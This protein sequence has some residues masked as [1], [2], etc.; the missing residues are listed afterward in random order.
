MKL[1]HNK[2]IFLCKQ[3]EKHVINKYYVKSLLCSDKIA[4]KK[5]RLLKYQDK[6]TKIDKIKLSCSVANSVV[7]KL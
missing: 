7:F 2:L 4:E 5:K 6:I 3:H 1:D